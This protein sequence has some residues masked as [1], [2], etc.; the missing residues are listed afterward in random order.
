MEEGMPMNKFPQGINY[1]S[2]P[3]K[4]FEKLVTDRKFHHDGNKVTEWMLS[5]VVIVA[6]PND[7]IKPHRGKSS[8]KIDGIIAT[9]NA[10]GGYMQE[11]LEGVQEKSIYEDRGIRTL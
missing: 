2:A 8:N 6:N 1:M 4:M 9:I 5:N 7:D 10:L 3:T 11:L